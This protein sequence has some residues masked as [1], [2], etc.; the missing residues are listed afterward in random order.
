MGSTWYYF[1]EE[2]LKF[3]EGY[4]PAKVKTYAQAPMF[5][6]DTIKPYYH[7]AAQKVTDSRSELAALDK[8]HRTITTDK[9]L[10]ASTFSNFRKENERKRRADARESLL[11]AVAQVDNGTAPL[12]EETRAKC[13]RQ[14]EIVSKALN[15]DAFNVAGNKRNKKG[16]KYGRR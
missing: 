12:S 11:K 9:P 16:K 14:N 8:A 13:A 6:S 10:E 1:D 4:P 3:V 15:F 5:I 2:S 7:P